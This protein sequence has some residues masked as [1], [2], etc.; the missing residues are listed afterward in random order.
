MEMRQR[1]L[2]ELESQER[3]LDSWFEP[4]DTCPFEMALEDSLEQIS[5]H[6]SPRNSAT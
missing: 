1:E 6:E 4:D 3:E 2:A 5:D